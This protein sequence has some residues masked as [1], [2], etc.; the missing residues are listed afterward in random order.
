[1][2]SLLPSASQISRHIVLTHHNPTG[3]KPG[4]PEIEHENVL[5]QLEDKCYKSSICS[6]EHDIKDK[7]NTNPWCLE[8]PKW[9]EMLKAITR[10]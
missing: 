5:H 7:Q 8:G 10:R 4:F 2:T 9:S 6:K 1:M 3:S